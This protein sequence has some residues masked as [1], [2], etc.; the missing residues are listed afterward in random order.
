MTGKGALSGSTKSAVSTLSEV[1]IVT[2]RLGLTGGGTT[3]RGLM[4]GAT[5]G[6]ITVPPVGAGTGVGIGA[7]AGT[8]VGSG[9]KAGAGPLSD[10]STSPGAKGTEI[11]WGPEGA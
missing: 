4:A 11:A 1:G 6:A 7:G 8:G 3:T 5:I 2:V 9:A 10:R